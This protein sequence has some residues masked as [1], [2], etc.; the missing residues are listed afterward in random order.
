MDRKNLHNRYYLKVMRGGSRFLLGRIK[1]NHMIKLLLEE[2]FGKKAIAEYEAEVKEWNACKW[3]VEHAQ[4]I[5]TFAMKNFFLVCLLLLSGCSLI[6]TSEFDALEYDGFIEI[7]T[8]SEKI[9]TMCDENNTR[10]LKIA[11]D[12]L[13]ARAHQLQNYV[14]HR[15]NNEDTTEIVSIIRDTA[16][17]FS[18]RYE[19]DGASSLYCKAKTEVIVEQTKLGADAVQHKVRR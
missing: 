18:S 8:L 10:Q 3:Y 4:P 2:E 12:I 11:T 7:M 15:P 9:H 17:E 14:S 19:N 1:K 6:Q 16:S 5:N 13:E